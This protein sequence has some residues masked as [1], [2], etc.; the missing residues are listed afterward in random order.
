MASYVGLVQFTIWQFERPLLD[1]NLHPS[2]VDRRLGSVR[3][4]KRNMGVYGYSGTSEDL[5]VK[6]VHPLFLKAKVAASAEENPNWR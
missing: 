2:A 3:A 6:Y 4:T 1:M 5:V